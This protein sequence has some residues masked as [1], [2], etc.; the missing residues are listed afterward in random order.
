MVV[1]VVA[2]R[3]RVPAEVE[4]AEAVALGDEE[5]ALV[6]GG[7]E[8]GVALDG[9]LAEQGEVGRVEHDDPS[10]VGDGDA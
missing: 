9:E 10:V 4:E 2:V 5:V 7:V 6:A 3:Q 8:P 1:V